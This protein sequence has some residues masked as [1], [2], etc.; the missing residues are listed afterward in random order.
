MPTDWY[1]P[2]ASDLLRDLRSLVT[3]RAG[4]GKEYIAVVKQLEIEIEALEKADL[5]AENQ[6]L[7]RKYYLA[8]TLWGQRKQPTPSAWRDPKRAGYTWGDWWRDKFGESMEEFAECAKSLGLR[9]R[10]REYELA[11]YGH[12]EIEEEL[13]EVA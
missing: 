10:I 4:Q 1:G 8:R 3:H 2:S 11:K 5:E 9:Q 7:L 6:L 13:E 12:S